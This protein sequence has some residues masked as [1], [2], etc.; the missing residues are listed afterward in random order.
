ME[1]EILLWLYEKIAP[2]AGG[3]VSTL[4][5]FIITLIGALMTQI[6]F[7]DV[8]PKRLMERLCQVVPGLRG[9]A[10]A[11][12]IVFLATLTLGA[13]VGF[14]MYGPSDVRQATLAGVGWY[15]SVRA[16][17][18]RLDE[19]RRGNGRGGPR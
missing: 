7:W 4:G 10:I 15:T 19:V 17:R 2:T 5:L 13:V 16:V 14:S 3:I 18:S 9:Y 8:N 6:L 11:P 12:P 1:P